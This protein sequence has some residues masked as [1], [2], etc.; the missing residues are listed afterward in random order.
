M[1]DKP[2]II[3]LMPDQLRPDFLSCYGAQFIDTPNIDF[4]C[5]HG[6]RFTNAYS[7][8]P[9]CVPARVSLMTGMHALKTGVLDNGQ[10]LRPDHRE[11]GMDTWPEILAESG[12][13]TAAIG[14]MHFYPW[15]LRLGFQYRRICED[16][17][18]IHIRDD[19]WDY[20]KEHGERKH[21][22]NEHEGYFDNRGAI[23]N[24]LPYELQWD[25]FVGLEASRFI[26][27]YGDDGPF[28][29]MVGFPGPHC[30]YDP[31]PRFLKLYDPEEMPAPVPDAGDTPEIRQNNINGNKGD[32]NGVDYTV[33]THA[34][35]RKI[36][37]H[38]A[39]LVKQI[40]EQVGEILNALREKGQ[41]ENTIILFSSDHGDY[42]GDHNLIGKGQYF[43]SSWHVPM[44]AYL[45]WAE[46]GSVC[47]DLVTLTDITA[48]MMHYAG[49][50]I[51][52]HMDSRPLPGLGIPGA[53]GR[54]FV[55]GA[56]GGGWA[57][58]DGKW[59]LAKYA[60]GEAVLF[61][62]EADP[63]EQHNLIDDPAHQSIYRQMDATLTHEVMRRSRQAFDPQR[64]YVTDLSQSNSFG[65]EGWVRPYP[66]S[67]QER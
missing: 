44:L 11:A 3:F 61:D 63:Q 7:E 46:Q 18:W 34:H 13:Y 8:H 6:V 35:K 17:R 43:E 40:D 38:Y 41:L 42:L 48:T 60:T 66:R 22:G 12:Y 31:D 30:P 67:V 47:D 26:R 57:I 24:R 33:F 51:P 5:Q 28:A 37:A 10:F 53:A 4:L 21:H 2:N 52:P 27:T 29:M 58:Y 59:R 20:L 50:E 36:R 9:V 16:K 54:E 14:K 1:P 19:Y 49:Q 23:V 32:W 65:R 62:I 15:D 56:L 39:A 25:Y 45:P 55:I 64:V